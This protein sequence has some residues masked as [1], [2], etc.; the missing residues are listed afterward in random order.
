MIA[1]IVIADGQFLTRTG[2]KA[3][4]DAELPFTVR[5]TAENSEALLRAL[6]THQ[7]DVLLIDPSDREHF[8]ISDLSV[9]PEVAPET[10]VMIVSDE[11]HKERIGDILDADISCFVTKQCSPSEIVQGVHAC[12]RGERFFCNKV[13]EILLEKKCGPGVDECDPSLLTRREE[14][15]VKLI[16]T[17]LGTKRIADELCLSTHTVN[18]H[19]KNIYRKLDVH[20]PVELVRYA[21]D[22]GIVEDPDR[23]FSSG[24]PE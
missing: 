2:L 10:R 19:R 8:A 5:A 9:I 21:M 13:L 22:L 14:E 11:K 24:G 7:P 12:T 1:D 4:L 3:V 6:E 16:A 23:S 15:I 18:T 17:G 20:S